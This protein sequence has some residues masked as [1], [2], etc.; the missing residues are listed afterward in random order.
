MWDQ[1]AAPWQAA[2]EQA[3]QAYCHGCVPIGAVITD[4]E[5]QIIARG[6]NRIY[7][8][9][10]EI[11]RVNG[12]R[13]AHAEIDALSSFHVDYADPQSCVLYSTMEP[14]PMCIGALRMCLIGHLQYAARDAMA[15][16]VSF[17]LASAFMQ[18]WPVQAVGPERFDLEAILIGLHTEWLLHLNLTL[19][20]ARD[21]WKADSPE[22]V[23]LG[24]ELFERGLLRQFAQSSVPVKD[25][26]SACAR[27]LAQQN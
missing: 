12:S 25:V 6:R 23:A 13:V 3:W 20:H 9:A 4:A 18:R 10:A 7:D 1:L 16:S 14:C 27:V 21:A 19:L 24:Q 2:I 15:G 8:Q 17:A 22:G 5:G 11:G 26:I